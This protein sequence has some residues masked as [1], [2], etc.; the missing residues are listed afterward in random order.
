[1]VT[2]RVF[3]RK[4]GGRKDTRWNKGREEG[5][6]RS[7]E[8]SVSGMKLRGAEMSENFELTSSGLIS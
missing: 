1:M 6:F 8:P 7:I 2:L 5:C 4:I 3:M